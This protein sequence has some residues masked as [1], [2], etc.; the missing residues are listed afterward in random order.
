[1]LRRKFTENRQE[2]KNV[3]QSIEQL[4]DQIASLESKKSV[5][6]LPSLGFAPELGEEYVRLMRDLKTNEAVFDALTKQYEMAKLTEV[7]D[8][9]AI[10]VVQPASIPEVRSWPA[11]TKMVLV[12]AFVAFVVSVFLCF[13]IEAFGRL[14]EVE[15][16]RWKSLLQVR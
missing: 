13:V 16:A 10:Q 7:N 14:P 9:S 6:A 11:R 3:L 4:K 15:R 5:G 12:A 2:V 1:V 8:V